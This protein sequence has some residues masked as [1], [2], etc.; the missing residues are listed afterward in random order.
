[1]TAD[2]QKRRPSGVPGRSLSLIPTLSAERSSGQVRADNRVIINVGGV[3]YETYKSTLRNIPDTRLSW[4]TETTAQNSDFDPGTGEY[5]FDRHPGVFNMILNYYRTGKLHTPVDVCGPMFEEELAFWGIDEKQIEPCCWMTYRTHRDAQ[6]TLAE[7]DG[8]DGDSDS[9]QEDNVAERF[10][11]LEENLPRVSWWERW[12]PRIWTLL[13]N[14]YSSKAAQ[15]TS[16][17][18]SLQS[19]DGDDDRVGYM[20]MI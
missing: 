20:G 16:T 6:E 19:D 15:V 3:R 12:Q 10:G 5:Y 8:G 9:D 14:P 7:L 17:N 11:I 4:I 13:E 2:A 18:L 1:M